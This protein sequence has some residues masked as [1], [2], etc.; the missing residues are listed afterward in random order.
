LRGI[1]SNLDDQPVTRAPIE[2]PKS[3]QEEPGRRQS[4][5]QKKREKK[6]PTTGGHTKKTRDKSSTEDSL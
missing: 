5:D 6:R 1:T 4:S 3:S 2:L